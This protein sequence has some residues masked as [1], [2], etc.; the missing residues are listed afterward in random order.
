VMLL[1]MLL[2]LLLGVPLIAALKILL[3]IFGELC[4]T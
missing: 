1:V 4:L 2:G 3:G